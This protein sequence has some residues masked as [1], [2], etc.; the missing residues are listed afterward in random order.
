MY[1]NL[2]LDYWW[3]GMKRDIVKYVEQCLTCLQVKFEHQQP[4][5][6]FQPLEIPVWKYEKITMDLIMKLAKTLRQCDAIWVIVD[7]LTKSAILLPI[8]ESMYSEALAEL[9]LYEVVARHEVPVSIVSD[10]DNRFTSRF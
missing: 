3:L 9:Y 2:K 8:K 4:Y 1:Y 10:R 6:K 5:G 7:H